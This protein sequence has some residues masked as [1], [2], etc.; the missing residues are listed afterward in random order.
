MIRNQPRSDARKIES[1]QKENARRFD[2]NLASASESLSEMDDKLN[3][4]IAIMD[5]HL[6]G[7]SQER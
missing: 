7:N 3:G 2:E 6:R 4:L 1:E 5:R